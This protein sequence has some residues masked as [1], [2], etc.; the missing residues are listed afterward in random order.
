MYDKTYPA[1][2]GWTAG[3]F[4]DA[5]ALRGGRVG[6]LGFDGYDQAQAIERDAHDTVVWQ[7]GEGGSGV[8]R[9]AVVEMP[10]GR[11]ALAGAS[12]VGWGKYGIALVKSRFGSTGFAAS[13]AASPYASLEGHFLALALTST[14]GL[15]AAGHTKTAGLVAAFDEIPTGLWY[16]EVP[17]TSLCRSVTATAADDLLTWCLGTGADGKPNGAVRVLAGGGDLKST[18]AIAA[19][20]G[21]QSFAPVF[22]PEGTSYLAFTVAPAAGGGPA[23]PSRVVV[24][25]VDSAGKVVWQRMIPSVYGLGAYDLEWSVNGPVVIGYRKHATTGDLN[26]WAAGLDPSGV[27]LWQRDYGGDGTDV[28][29]GGTALPD[30]LLFVGGT[31]SQGKAQ[32]EPWAVRTDAWGQAPCNKSGPCADLAAKACDDGKPCTADTCSPID[33]CVSA[34]TQCD[35]GN[36]CTSDACDPKAGCVWSALPDG[37]AACPGG[38]QCGGGFCP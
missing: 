13:F 2:D 27:L 36:P 28:F 14:T 7:D 6:Y 30:G 16:K 17:A 11:V 10:D 38:G 25:R 37:T 3:Y 33:G 22:A 12:F 19:P 15:Y 34:P 32:Q 35:D 1:N 29:Y 20:V 24:L 8:S 9:R 21:V 5:V 18:L 26:G 4:T 31:N 23:K